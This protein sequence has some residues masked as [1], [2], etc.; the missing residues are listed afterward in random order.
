VNFC[1]SRLADEL[2][3]L[4]PV[5]APPVEII[6]EGVEGVE[7][8]EVRTACAFRSW[9]LFLVGRSGDESARTP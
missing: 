6:G 4:V 3:W 1:V 2:P 7:G 9:L 8:V 5:T